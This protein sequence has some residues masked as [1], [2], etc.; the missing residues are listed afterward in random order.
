M[1]LCFLTLICIVFPMIVS[2]SG[3]TIKYQPDELSPAKFGTTY[4]KQVELTGGLVSRLYYIIH[5]SYA[6][7]FRTEEFSPAL[8]NPRDIKENWDGIYIKCIGGDEH[9]CNTIEIKG[10]IN[11]EEDIVIELDGYTMGAGWSSGKESHKTFTIHV[12]K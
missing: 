12:E 7:V 10:N 2:C 1:K 9:R 11:V 6:G 8:E 4:S 3:N 5:P